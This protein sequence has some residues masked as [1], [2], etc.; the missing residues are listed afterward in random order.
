MRRGW[1]R[2]AVDARHQQARAVAIAIAAAAHRAR[3][4][5]AEQRSRGRRRAGRW[6]EGLAGEEGP[7][8]LRGGGCLGDKGGQAERWQS[9]GPPTWSHWLGMRLLCLCVFVCCV[10]R[11]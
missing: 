9:A 8:E 1:R 4:A 2:A 5:R 11:V 3:G 10:L 7:G 6:G